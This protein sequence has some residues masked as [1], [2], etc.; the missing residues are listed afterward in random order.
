[1]EHILHLGHFM[2]SRRFKDIIAFRKEQSAPMAFH[3]RNL[4]VAEISED[5]WNLLNNPEANQDAYADL[6]EWESSETTGNSASSNGFGEVRSLTINVTQICN[7][8]CTYCAAGGDGTY[9]FAQTK[10]NV[11]KTLPQLKFFMEKLPENSRF[12]ITFL[13]GEPLLYP[14]GIRAIG[15]YVSE[16]G[17]D[18]KLVAEFSIVTNGTLLSEDNLELLSDIKA[19]ITISLDGPSAINDRLRPS[20]SGQSSTEMIIAGI[21]RL[22]KH[23]KNLGMVRVHGVFGKDN[24][25]LLKAYE[26]YESLN[27]D[28][29]E[30]SFSVESSDELTNRSFIAE[31]NAIAALA[32]ARGGESGIRKIGFF[33]QQF[34]ILDR[35]IQI[36]NH[37]PAGK[38]FLMV[39]A[40]NNLYTCPWDVGNV[41]TKVGQGTHLDVEKLEEYRE[42]LVDKNNCQNCWARFMC[43]GGCMFI[44][45][46][47]T[48]SKHKKDANFCTRTRDLISTAIFYYKLSRDF[49]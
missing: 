46:Q 35:Q 19:N 26:F 24:T 34:S 11:E 44:H 7:L 14:E 9:G 31:M 36:K 33:D 3:A 30:F 5:L 22:Q 47:A 16:V 1:M 41:S 21:S 8:K 23:R 4:E 39:D 28:Q 29:Y 32:Y 43:G 17:K 38:N 49:C 12:H 37:C 48:G 6:I 20:K 27:V 25:E 18:K 15:A 45:Q 10:I 40:Q 13:G 2:E 42:N